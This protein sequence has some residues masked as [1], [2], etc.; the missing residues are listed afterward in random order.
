LWLFDKRIQFDEHPELIELRKREVA[1]GK[2]KGP[3]SG[4]SSNNFCS[5]LIHHRDLS[6]PPIQLEKYATLW[7]RP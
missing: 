5:A 1:E 4:K 2:R 3:K 6:T 7:R